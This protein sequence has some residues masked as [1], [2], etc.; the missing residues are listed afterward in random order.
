MPSEGKYIY[1]IIDSREEI[2]FGPSGIGG[3]GD[4]VHSVPFEDIAA[5]V[6]DSPVVKYSISRE[7]TMTHMKVMEMAMKDYTILPVKFGTIAVGNN[8]RSPG[9]RIK[10]EILKARHKEL[11]D[12]LSRMYNKTELGLKAIWTN[13]ET[14]FQEIVD[15]NREIRMLKK[16]LVSRNPAQ[17]HSQRTN[18]GE[19]V[20]KSLETK[21]AKEETEIL[22]P[23]KCVYYDIR[24]N[25]VFGDS[26][27]T[28]SAF[29]IDKSRVKE[30][31]QLVKKLESTYDCRTKFKYVGPVPPC[32]I[33]ELVIMLKEEKE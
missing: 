4:R 25:E 14:I 27:V 10:F 19:M 28:N 30:S 26:M 20:K 31:D 11:K 12:L 22:K 9:E 5:V 33:V 24:H 32:N 21:K 3:R 17:T 2:E 13:M 16:R 23:L 18:L 1:C 6:S 8:S 15:E 7:N 29:L